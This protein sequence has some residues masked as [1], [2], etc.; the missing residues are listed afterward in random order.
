MRIVRRDEQARAPEEMPAAVSDAT[1]ALIDHLTAAHAAAAEW[2]ALTAAGSELVAMGYSAWLAAAHPEL[3]VRPSCPSDGEPPVGGWIDLTPPRDADEYQAAEEAAHEEHQARARA[4]ALWPTLAPR[5]ARLGKSQDR[6]LVP[7][8]DRDWFYATL[9]ALRRT[10][11][12]WFY[13]ELHERF[14]D[15]DPRRAEPP[16]YEALS[17]APLSEM[18]YARA[19]GLAVMALA[20]AYF[21]VVPPGGLPELELEPEPAAPKKRPKRGKLGLL[22]PRKVKRVVPTRRVAAL[23]QQVAVAVAAQRAVLAEGPS[24]E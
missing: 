17:I 11:R 7:R 5:L 8:D 2:H 6:R 15:G 23:A 12:A 1:A 18:K 14:P 20:D 19:W 21:G 13:K 16:D 10:D 22:A 24:H 4:E 3:I 9:K